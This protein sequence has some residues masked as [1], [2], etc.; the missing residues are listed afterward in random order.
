M[1]S[2]RMLLYRTRWWFIVSFMPFHGDKLVS[3]LYLGRYLMHGDTKC[4][5]SYLK[6]CN[7]EGLQFEKKNRKLSN[8]ARIKRYTLLSSIKF[9]FYANGD[10][11]GL[12]AT[13][14]GAHTTHDLKIY[15]KWTKRHSRAI[16]TSFKRRHTAWKYYVLSQ[17]FQGF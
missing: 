13:A 12:K 3:G 6:T 17:I 10:V 14:Q 7:Y 16:N 4:P 15:Q 9:F 11:D 8:L 1:M 2:H 5:G